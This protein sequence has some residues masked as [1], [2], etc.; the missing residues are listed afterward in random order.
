MTDMNDKTRILEVINQENNS[1]TDLASS[2]RNL[3]IL[4]ARKESSHIKSP[5]NLLLGC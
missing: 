2:H 1:K 4:A 3:V 5:P